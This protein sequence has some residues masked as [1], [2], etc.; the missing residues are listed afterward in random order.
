MRL[1]S[2]PLTHALH[3]NT[4]MRSHSDK[5]ALYCITEHELTSGWW[6]G[7]TK[8]SERIWHLAW[9]RTVM[10]LLK[11]CRHAQEIR[12]ISFCALKIR[13]ISLPARVYPPPVRPSVHWMYMNWFAPH[14]SGR[15]WPMPHSCTAYD[16]FVISV[17]SGQSEAE[18]S[19]CYT[20]MLFGKS[21]AAVLVKLINI[22][23]NWNEKLIF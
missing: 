1:W 7:V 22:K 14:L 10:S 8:G 2:A 19:L 17:V 13:R 20:F 11:F 23:N 21:Q 9:S 6:H 18:L 15:R 12:H 3:A 16:K 5:R 4:R